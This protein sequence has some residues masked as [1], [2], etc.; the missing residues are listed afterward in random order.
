MLTRDVFDIIEREIK[1]AGFSE[2]IPAHSRLRAEIQKVLLSNRF[3]DLPNTVKNYQQIISRLMELVETNKD[4][5][6]Y[7]E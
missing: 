2:S 5:I 4:I 6:I 7:A 1:L 3:K